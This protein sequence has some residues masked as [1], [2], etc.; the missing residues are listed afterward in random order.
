MSFNPFSSSFAYAD[1]MTAFFAFQPFVGHNFI[2]HCMY[3]TD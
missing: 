1:V 2:N 3:F